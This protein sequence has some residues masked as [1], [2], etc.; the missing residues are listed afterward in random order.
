[1]KAFYAINKLIIFTYMS[2]EKKCTKFK[3]VYIL[4]FLIALIKH[5][6]VYDK[7]LFN[8]KKS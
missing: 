4:Y 7:Y 3:D 6:L 8:K 5:L 1:M 2:I